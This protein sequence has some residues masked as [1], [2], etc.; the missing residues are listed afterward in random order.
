M[1]DVNKSLN[2]MLGHEKEE[3]DDKVDRIV[4]AGKLDKDVYAFLK[5]NPNPSD[6]KVHDWAEKKGFNIHQVE[7]AI[8]KLATKQVHKK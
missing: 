7:A 1:F 5:S 3:D 8:Y 6:D 4:N 2:K